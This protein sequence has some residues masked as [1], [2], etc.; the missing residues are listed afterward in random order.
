M[1]GG[2]EKKGEREWGGREARERKRERGGMLNLM[3]K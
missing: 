1:R 2:G 3:G